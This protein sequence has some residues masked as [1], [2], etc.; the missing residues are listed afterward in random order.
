MS[1]SDFK[2][3]ASDK[4]DGYRPEVDAEALWAQLEPQIPKR[5]NKRRFLFWLFLSGLAIGITALG[6]WYTS[7]STTAPAAKQ[8]I[9]IAQSASPKEHKISKEQ[10]PKTPRKTKTPV[11]TF[12]NTTETKTTSVSKKTNPESANTNTN[13]NTNHSNAFASANLSKTNPTPKSTTKNII[14][15]FTNAEI[16]WQETTEAP[17]KNASNIS[18]NNLQTSRAP[19]LKR[20]ASRSTFKQ[21][22][23]KKFTVP[24]SVPER[25]ISLIFSSKE[26]EQPQKE[27]IIRIQNK[28]QWSLGIHGG[29]GRLDQNLSIKDQEEQ[30]YLEERLKTE[31]P[32]EALHGTLD[33]RIKHRSGIYLQTGL[34]YAR[35]ASR[36]YKKTTLQEDYILSNGIQKIY[37]NYQTG[38]SIA[39]YGPITLTNISESTKTRFNNFHT[40]NIPLMIGYQSNRGPWSW[41]AEAG[42]LVNAYFKKSGSISDRGFELYK[43]EQDEQNWFKNNLGLRPMVAVH[44]GYRIRPDWE[45][46][47]SPQYRF[48]I[49][50]SSVENPIKHR[51]SSLEIAAGVRVRL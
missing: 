45:I 42:V 32:L 38:D 21:L 37:T 35:M 15:N 39:V 29:A 8:S 11:N 36:Y 7:P 12:S 46:Y 23:L 43:L 33:F 49:N 24:L 18:I 27:E 22:I 28:W 3:D 30:L 44:A 25:N 1:F 2:K 19:E 6:W 47:L 17:P 41:G 14:E 26:A 50:M 20:M 34:E 9:N 5:E 31:K 48:P 40:L 10:T 51:F 16:V 4:L 13:T